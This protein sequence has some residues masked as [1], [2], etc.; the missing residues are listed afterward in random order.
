MHSTLSLLQLRLHFLKFVATC[1]SPAPPKGVTVVNNFD[2]RNVTSAH[3]MRSRASIIDLNVGWN[4]SKPPIA[5]V[6]MAGLM[7]SIK[8]ITRAGRCGKN[9]KAKRICTSSRAAPRS[10][11]LFRPVHHG[12]YNVIALDREYRHALVCGGSRLSVDTLSHASAF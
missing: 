6:T 4:K 2:A 7:S 1:S 8:A 11:S 9:K 10:K 12:G 3:G 5:C